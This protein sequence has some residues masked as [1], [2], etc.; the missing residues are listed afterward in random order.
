MA[1]QQARGLADLYE[2]SVRVP[3]VAADLCSAID[4]RRHELCSLRLP[5]LVAGADVSDPQVQEDR[6]GVAALVVDY[7]DAWLVGGG[8]PAGVHDDPRV[9]KPDRARI[10]LQDDGATQD[11]GVEVP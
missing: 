5:L 2:V 9:G 11:A 6:G 7:R 3:H 4:R 8:G 10:F 1:L